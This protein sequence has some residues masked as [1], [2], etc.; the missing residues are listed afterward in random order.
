MKA[1]KLES[2]LR[3]RLLSKFFT[4][5]GK[6]ATL[7]L[8]YD[9]FEELVNPNFGDEHTEKLNEKLFSDIREAAEIL[10]RT[11]KLNV[12]VHIRDFGAYAREEC[13]EII[14]QNI[15]LSAYLALKS[16]N[17]HRW[18]GWALIG[19]GAAVLIVSYFLQSAKYDILFD[20]VNISGTL[21]VWEGANTAFLERNM[22]FSAAKRLAKALQNVSV[23]GAEAPA[24][25]GE[26]AEEPADP[27]DMVRA[28]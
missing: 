8:F 4:I 1:K 6:I 12:E 26:N 11:Y 28:E 27:A 5:E 13:E 10:P 25:R 16:G 14:L 7:K 3:D 23:M 17:G 24:E 22:E 20:I 21:F 19:A 2:E 9:T 15:K 18:S